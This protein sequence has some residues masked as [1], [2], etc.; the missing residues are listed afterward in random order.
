MNMIIGA[1]EV[2]ARLAPTANRETLVALDAKRRTLDSAAKVAIALGTVDDQTL[3]DTGVAHVAAQE[4]IQYRFGR[5]ESE[6]VC[7]IQA[8]PRDSRSRGTLRPA[9][10]PAEL[11]S[12]LDYIESRVTRVIRDNGTPLHVLRNGEAVGRLDAYDITIGG[13]KI[14]LGTR[15]TM[16]LADIVATS[17]NEDD[18]DFGILLADGTLFE[19]LEDKDFVWVDPSAAVAA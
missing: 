16:E 4:A 6:A 11:A 8:V 12:S 1:F 13:G 5:L 15:G 10:T 17:I 3:L 19:I 14:A 7:I 2:V 9:A 18:E